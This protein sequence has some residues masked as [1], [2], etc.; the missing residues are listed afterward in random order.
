MLLDCQYGRESRQWLPLGMENDAATAKVNRLCDRHH[1]WVDAVHGYDEEGRLYPSHRPGER[2]VVW[3]VDL[4]I[5]DSGFGTMGLWDYGT[6][7]LWGCE[8]SPSDNI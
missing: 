3:N 1:F 2:A 7:G 4:G 5:R 6:M 8:M